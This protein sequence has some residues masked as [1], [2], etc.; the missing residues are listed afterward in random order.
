MNGIKDM[1]WLC[2]VELIKTTKLIT[3]TTM[4]DDQKSPL[5]SIVVPSYNQGEF[6]KQ[7]IDSILAQDYAP[8]QIIVVDGASTDNTVKILKSYGDRRDL[9]WLSEP[10]RGVVDAVNKGFTLAQGKIIGIQSS[11]DLYLPKAISKVI[12]EF[13]RDDSI[14]LVYGDSIKIDAFGNEIFRAQTSQFS[15]RNMLLAKTWIP[16]SAAFFRRELIDICGG[17][18]EEISYVA[19]TDLW[20]RIA[21]RTKVLK[22]NDF[23]GQ[24]RA[25]ENQRDKQALKISRDYC[26]M[27]DYSDDI[28]SAS[29]EIKKAAKASKYLIKVRYNQTGQHWI[30]AWN[31][32]NAGLIDKSVMQPK[33]IFFYA[34]ELPIRS[35]LSSFKRKITNFLSLN[36]ISSNNPKL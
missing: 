5:V 25:H 9:I 10:D 34:L 30:S 17:W 15:I 13:K 8:I 14:G 20:L 16:Q 7:T 21:F 1:P 24:H 4:N 33:R 23:L 32:L 31:L 29:K 36:E 12:N 11:D 2:N 27:I 6:I 19:D 18:N 22:V 28:A 35:F 26:K 3:L